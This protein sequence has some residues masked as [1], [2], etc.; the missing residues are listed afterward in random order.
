MPPGFAWWTG[1]WGQWLLVGMVAAP[2]VAVA[3]LDL[4][5][6]LDKRH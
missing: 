4:M 2:I 5:V 1:S 3:V 6:W